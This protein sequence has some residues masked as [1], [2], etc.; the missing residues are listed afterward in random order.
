MSKTPK[1]L[2]ESTRSNWGFLRNIYPERWR[3][4]V[5]TTHKNSHKNSTQKYVA[6]N[7]YDFP[8]VFLYVSKLFWVFRWI[9]KVFW[10][11]GK[12]S[13]RIS[14][15][16]HQNPTTGS[17][18]SVKKSFPEIFLNFLH[19]VAK[20]NKI[21]TCSRTLPDMCW[22]SCKAKSWTKSQDV[23]ELTVHFLKHR[24][25]ILFLK[26]NLHRDRLQGPT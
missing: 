18:K 24:T 21:R 20:T 8:I 16:F 6:R 1:N 3:S 4:T 2:R 15:K 23:G 14:S 11:S 26:A 5:R 17:P 25:R 19:P 7:I 10:R 22:A 9:L 12:V 13:D